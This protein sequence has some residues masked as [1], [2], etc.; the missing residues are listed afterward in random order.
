VNAVVKRYDRV[1]R[2][3]SKLLTPLA[4]EV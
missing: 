3:A 2:V 4:S 1:R